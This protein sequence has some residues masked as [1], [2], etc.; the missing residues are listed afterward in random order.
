MMTSHETGSNDLRKLLFISYAYEDQAFAKWLARKLAFYGYGI[1]F[2]QIKLLGGESWV[3]DVDIAI[4]EHSCRVLALLSKSSI[5]KEHPRKERTMAQAVGKKLGIDDFLIPLNLDGT[6]PD[7]KVSDISWISCKYSW[8]EGLRRLLKKL[9]SIDAPKIHEGNPAI[10][11]VELSDGSELVG[12]E[13]EELVINWIPFENLPEALRIYDAPGLEKKDLRDWP[14][15]SL[16]DGKVA[17]LSDPPAILSDRVSKTKE[18]YAW[19]SVDEIRHSATHSIIIQIL[20]KAVRIWLHE[21]GCSYTPEARVTHL[22]DPYKEESIYRYEDADGKKRRICASGKITVKK[23]SAPPE[24]VI[25]HPGVRYRARRTDAGDY[26]LELTPSVALFDSHHKAYEGTKIGPRRKKV[27]QG[28]YNPHWRKRLMAFAHLVREQAAIDKG[29]GF[30]LGDPIRLLSDRS[31]ISVSTAA[32]EE[33][34]EEESPEEEVEVG[35]NEMEDW[36]S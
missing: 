34:P 33:E 13:P 32:S 12:P 22:P 21:A 7:W 18:A 28:W 26:V 2:D 11:A 25:H 16:G 14:C 5:S 36:Q 15:F 4:K 30:G 9:N 3:E 20:N 17:A 10:A 1:W 8:A 31:L 24:K 6:D 29:L 35:I 19:R 27:S 23:P